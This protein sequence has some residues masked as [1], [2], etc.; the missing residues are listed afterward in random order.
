MIM[1]RYKRQHFLGWRP[2]HCSLNV[3][4]RVMGVKNIMYKNKFGKCW[5]NKGK[6]VSSQRDFSEP[7]LS[8]YALGILTVAVECAVFPDHGH[9]LAGSISM[10]TV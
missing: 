9:F 3:T 10:P 8:D 5:L 1:E 7:L 4:G 6:V 2:G